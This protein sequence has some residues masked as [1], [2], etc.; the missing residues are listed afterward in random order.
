MYI[1]KNYGY[2]DKWQE[3]HPGAAIMQKRSTFIAIDELEQITDHYYTEVG[4]SENYPW[5]DQ[6]EGA[7]FTA[8]C[9]MHDA[10]GQDYALLTAYY[11]DELC[12]KLGIILEYQ[13][14]SLAAGLMRGIEWNDPFAAPLSMQYEE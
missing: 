3:E 1:G 14:A 11:F 13:K 9:N 7:A 10:K 6:L 4:E 12:E 8:Y 5:D 2:I